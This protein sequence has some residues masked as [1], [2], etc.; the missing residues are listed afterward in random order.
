MVVVTVLLGFFP[1]GLLDPC[2]QILNTFLQLTHFVAEVICRTSSELGNGFGCLK[3]FEICSP[4]VLEG[5]HTT[6][7]LLVLG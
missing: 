6:N 4:V 2:A 5:T 1:G 7:V 3:L